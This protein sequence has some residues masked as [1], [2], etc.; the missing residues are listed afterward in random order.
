MFQMTGQEIQQA[1]EAY[2]YQYDNRFAERNFSIAAGHLRQAA[3]IIP[4]LFD[5]NHWRVLLTHRSEELPEHRGQVAYPGGAHE[6]SDENLHQTAL[7]EMQEEIGVH[8]SD[9]KV[10]GHLGDMPIVTG[11]WVRLFVGQIP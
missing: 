6:R 9:V 10:F 8:P 3:V 5:E 4:L 11:Y 7:R 2:Q 1:V